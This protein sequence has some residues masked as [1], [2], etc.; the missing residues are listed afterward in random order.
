MFLLLFTIFFIGSLA[1]AMWDW[2]KI[3]NLETDQKREEDQGYPLWL[4]F[5]TANDQWLQTESLVICGTFC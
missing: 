2:K 1:T 5:S 3:E 4:F